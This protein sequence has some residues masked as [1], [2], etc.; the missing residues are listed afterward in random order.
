MHTSIRL[1]V[2]RLWSPAAVLGLQRKA[3][4]RAA[5]SEAQVHRCP[6]TDEGFCADTWDG[7]TDY[8]IGMH[9]CDQDMHGDKDR[10][11]LHPDY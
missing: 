1:A 2:A 8:R 6:G 11:M 3:S 7:R 4:R 9:A 5:G 10:Q